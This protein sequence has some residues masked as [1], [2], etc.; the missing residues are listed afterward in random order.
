MHAREVA[1]ANH[2]QRR[3]TYKLNRRTHVQIHVNN[4][5]PTRTRTRGL[6]LIPQTRTQQKIPPAYKDPKT[7][8]TSGRQTENRCGHRSHRTN[9]PTQPCSTSTDPSTPHYA[10]RQ[11]SSATSKPRRTAHSTHPENPATLTTPERFLQA[12]QQRI[13]PHRTS[14]G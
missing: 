13:Y 8:S 4:K 6:A 1:K 3:T 9:E 12:R 10:G 11:R 14:S 5:G 7:S 2:E